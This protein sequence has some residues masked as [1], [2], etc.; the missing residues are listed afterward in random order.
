VRLISNI[1]FLARVRTETAEHDAN[2]RQVHPRFGRFLL[3]LVILGHPPVA[4]DPGDGSLHD[5]P[6]RLHDEPLGRALDDL[7]RHPQRLL[8]PGDQ[9]ARVTLIRPDQQERRLLALQVEEQCIGRL[10]VLHIGRRYVG[11]QQESTGVDGQE[12]FTS[13]YAFGP[14]VA[15]CP[16]F[17][18]VLAVWLSMMAAVGAVLL[19]MAT[20]TSSRSASWTRCHVP[21]SRHWAK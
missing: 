17:S 14:V 7:Q 10:A 3:L 20:R 19:P 11:Q 8:G 16:P 9:L 4:P 13:N 21:S 5:P 2:H 18:V 12:P 6:L 15:P 1:C